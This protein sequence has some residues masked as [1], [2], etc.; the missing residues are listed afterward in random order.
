MVSGEE[1]VPPQ[2]PQPPRLPRRW[3]LPAGALLAVGI[4]A[5][6]LAMRNSDGPASAPRALL[7]SELFL[8]AGLIAA[9]RRPANPTG[10]LMI[11]YAVLHALSFAQD[12]TLVPWRYTVGLVFADLDTPVLALLVVMFP[13]GRLDN[14]WD[15]ALSATFF[16]V[17]W[18]TRPFEVFWSPPAALCATC[19]PSGNLLYTG[20][21]PFDLRD[22]LALRADVRIALIALVMMTLLVRF[23]RATRPAKRV[24]APLVLTTVLLAGKTVADNVVI[25]G[26]LFFTYYYD[27]LIATPNFV[28]TCAIPVAFGLGVLQTRVT[29]S[30]IGRLLLDLERRPRTGA[31]RDVLARALGD[32][33]LR[34]GFW[35]EPLGRYVGADGRPLALPADDD[36]A[37]VSAFSGENGPLAVLIHDP[38]LREDPELVDAVVAAARLSLEN[39]RLRAEVRAQL[40]QVQASRAR[41]VAAADAERRRIER[42]LH[43]GA[44]QRLVSLGLALRLMGNHARPDGDHERL[45]RLLA[46]AGDQAQAAIDELRDLARGIHPSVLTDEGLGVALEA[47][48]HRAPV[49]VVLERVPEGRLPAAIEVAAYF[50]C[51]E[52]ITNAAK[53]AG[54][55][56]VRIDVTEADGAVRVVVAD[57]GPG[58]AR[59]EGGTGLR[60]LTDRVEALG[61]TL[62]VESPSG[63]GTR[64]VAELPLSPA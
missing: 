59:V 11:A 32:P 6:L 19:A 54:D 4:A 60:G 63:A 25:E 47:L 3:L 5:W 12:E 2:P 30:S 26:R 23:V 34:V 14:W 33:S 61:G 15:R 36:R 55:G 48:A 1:E 31:L 7:V 16:V 50:V 10:V 42:D 24:M 57:A 62:A 46:E 18:G 64:L 44:Q 37:V 53:Y 8:L 58:G 38:V 43:D 29:R 41:I 49:P 13:Y 9:V 45:G 35:A 27:D 28:L 56:T 20:P 52:A 17:V 39:E 51:S 22:A 40:E 21:A